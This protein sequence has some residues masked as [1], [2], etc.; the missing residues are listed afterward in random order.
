MIHV[1]FQSCSFLMPLDWHCFCWLHLF[2]VVYLPA[3]L[4]LCLTFLTI[5]AIIILTISVGLMSSDRL[6]MHQRG[7]RSLKEHHIKHCQPYHQT[8]PPQV[9][10]LEGEPDFVGCYKGTKWLHACWQTP[11]TPKEHPSS[12][13]LVRCSTAW[14]HNEHDVTCITYTWSRKTSG[15][16]ELLAVIFPK[17]GFYGCIFAIV[18]T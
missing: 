6:N 8:K 3:V 12:M 14:T 2:D 1:W 13:H 18:C 17:P 9:F 11:R 10:G 4:G 5:L 15:T 16:F 7:A